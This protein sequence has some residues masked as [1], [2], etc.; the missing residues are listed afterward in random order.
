MALRVRRR[1]VDVPAPGDARSFWLQE[2]LAADPAA[3]CPALEGH[4]RA[5]AVIV[6]G[7]FAG[8]WTAVRLLVRTHGRRT[9]D[10]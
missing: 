2:A 8:L 4:V 10:Q 3:A 5:D 1:Q 9:P 7:G 6:G